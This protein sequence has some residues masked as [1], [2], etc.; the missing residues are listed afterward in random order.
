MFASDKV[1]QEP[2]DADGRYVL[3]GFRSEQVALFTRQADA[4]WIDRAWQDV[5][6]GGANRF[7]NDEA[8]ALTLP[9]FAECSTSDECLEDQRCELR[10]CVPDAVCGDDSECPACTVCD[11]TRAVCVPREGAS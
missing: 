5:E 11:T 1:E 4:G 3:E 2:A 9:D 8:T 10:R 7:C 6:C